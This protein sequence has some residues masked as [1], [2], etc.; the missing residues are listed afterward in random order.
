MLFERKNKKSLQLKHKL[1]ILFCIKT[2]FIEELP[3][4]F[5]KFWEL[6]EEEKKDFV[7]IK[8]DIVQEGEIVLSN[9]NCLK[10]LI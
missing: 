2:G 6:N 3:E 4:N 1:F 10:Y 7:D 8:C 9:V 5:G